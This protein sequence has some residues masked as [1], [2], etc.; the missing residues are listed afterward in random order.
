MIVPCP[1][2]PLANPAFAAHKLL[3][4]TKVLHT[5]RHFTARR[6]Q[7]AARAIVK[8]PWL[9]TVCQ[10]AAV[11]IGI[12]APTPLVQL[13]QNLTTPSG[14]AAG[15]SSQG[16]DLR[17]VEPAASATLAP[18][19]GGP[20]STMMAPVNVEPSPSLSAAQFLASSDDLTWPSALALPGSMLLPVGTDTALG[21]P[22]PPQP[23]PEP[24]TLP[25]LAAAMC[26][27]ALVR[28][29]GT[30]KVSRIRVAE[31][32]IG[33]PIGSNTASSPNTR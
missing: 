12:I 15:R 21:N 6:I 18:I 26:G 4:G 3:H 5:V 7:H 2:V 14:Q 22:A 29:R 33:R 1:N 32:E 28:G 10:V 16:G 27:V 24:A 19:R 23:A 20:D 8:R 31:S 11:G 17:W 13:P 30:V 25:V 9:A